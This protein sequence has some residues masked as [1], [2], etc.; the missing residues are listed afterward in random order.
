[1]FLQKS[2]RFLESYDSYLTAYPPA[3]DTLSALESRGLDVSRLHTSTQELSSLLTS[4]LHYLPQLFLTLTAVSSRLD[5]RSSRRIGSGVRSLY[6]VYTK[7]VPVS[8]TLTDL[9]LEGSDGGSVGCHADEKES[10]ER[11]V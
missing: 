11:E 5:D 6:R 7:H 10:D 9:K 8:V 3:L 4:P 2:A 1:M